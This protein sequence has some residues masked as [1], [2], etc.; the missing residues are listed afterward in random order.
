MAP[1]APTRLS[2]L[3]T[4]SI[5]GAPNLAR[6]LPKITEGEGPIA[7]GP[8][9]RG[10][11]GSAAS[12]I[13]SAHRP[14]ARIR[15]R[16]KWSPSRRMLG[17]ILRAISAGATS[18]AADANSIM[19]PADIRASLID[20]AISATWQCNACECEPLVWGSFAWRPVIEQRQAA[21]GVAGR[22]PGRI[23]RASLA[24]EPSNRRASRITIFFCW[25]AMAGANRSQCSANARCRERCT[26]SVVAAALSR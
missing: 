15:R 9:R 3:L 19:P 25:G 1:L 2:S 5:S 7:A 13:T 4:R 23:V 12:S 16:C 22:A 10:S 20:P 8:A 18:E 6:S 24:P 17:R 21:V 11:S 26:L 14:R